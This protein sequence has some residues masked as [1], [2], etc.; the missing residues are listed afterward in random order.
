MKAITQTFLNACDL[1]IESIKLASE[2]CCFSFVWK[3]GSKVTQ[4]LKYESNGATVLVREM[5]TLNIRTSIR[6]GRVQEKNV[7]VFIVQT[8]L[9]LL[10]TEGAEIDQVS[11]PIHRWRSNFDFIEIPLGGGLMMA[12]VRLKRLMQVENYVYTN[13]DLSDQ[14]SSEIDSIKITP[15][16]TKSSNLID[17]QKDELQKVRKELEDKIYYSNKLKSDRNILI[18]KNLELEGQLSS[19]KSTIKE[20]WSRMERNYKNKITIRDQVY[21]E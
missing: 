1:Y 13:S 10:N 4:S 9:Y 18:T 3:R 12:K 8:E 6:N 7:S 20:Q 11:L 5:L 14:E 2:G 17:E 16:A 21:E 19:L 15:K